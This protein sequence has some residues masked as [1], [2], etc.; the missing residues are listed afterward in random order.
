MYRSDNIK[1]GVDRTPNVSLLYALG[2]TKEEIS[3]PIIGVVSSFSEVV[4]G[5]MHLDKIAQAVKEGVYAAGGTP[6]I[7]PAIA[8]CDGI[9]MGHVGMKYSLVSRDLVA[10]STE[11]M[12]IAHQFDG[13]V[14]IQLRQKRSR[15]FNGC[16]TCQ[17][18]D[19][20]LRRRPHAGR[21]SQ[22]RAQ[23]LFKPHV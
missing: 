5:H 6:I 22:R 11:A 19:D 18:P 3:R 15:A 1:A 14:M 12:A 2:L 16:G 8:V 20:F 7:I 9:A 21:S 17:C 23:D 4:P 10:D 13:L